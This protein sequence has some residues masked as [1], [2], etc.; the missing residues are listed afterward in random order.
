MESFT[1]EVIATGLPLVHPLLLPPHS[2]AQVPDRWRRDHRR[3]RPD[4]RLLSRGQMVG[5]E[6]EQE[7]RRSAGVDRRRQP[8]ALRYLILAENKGERVSKCSQ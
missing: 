7:T 4:R 1:D 2:R 5:D 3:L 8:L 6:E